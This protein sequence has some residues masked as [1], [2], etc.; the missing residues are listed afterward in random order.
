MGKHARSFRKHGGIVYVLATICLLSLFAQAQVVQAMSSTASCIA[1]LEAHTHHTMAHGCCANRAA[2]CGCS[3]KQGSASEPS[4]AIAP[5]SGS[6]SPQSEGL[7]VCTVEPITL[8]N[9]RTVVESAI[10]ARG[11]TIKVYLQTL[12][13]IC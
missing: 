5:A 13:L 6:C 10:K 4:P 12:S 2:A 7:A 3:L 9:E 1:A 11:P 8:T